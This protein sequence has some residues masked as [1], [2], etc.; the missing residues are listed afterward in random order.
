MAMAGIE[1]PTT[2]C[3]KKIS[4]LTPTEVLALATP[5]SPIDRGGKCSIGAPCLLGCIWLL[6]HLPVF[7][8][9]LGLSVT[10]HEQLVTCGCL[11]VLL[12]LSSSIA[13]L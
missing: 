3:S 7:L 8:I 2:G 10:T 11:F 4:G 9:V 12:V 1:P 5:K 6:D 13:M